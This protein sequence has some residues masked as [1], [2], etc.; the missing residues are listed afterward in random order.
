MKGHWQ[1][2][3]PTSSGNYH[4]ADRLGNYAGIRSVSYDPNT[5][6]LVYVQS[7]WVGWWWSEPVI[8]PLNPP[9]W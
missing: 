9:K 4:T 8:A 7:N 3:L 2:E 1:K 6:R 5:G